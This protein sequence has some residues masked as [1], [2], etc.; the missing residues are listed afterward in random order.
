MDTSQL[1]Q[2]QYRAWCNRIQG[3]Y[4][5]DRNKKK[6]LK[7]EY[8]MNM[9]SLECYNTTLRTDI[10][11]PP[12]VCSS[13]QERKTPMN[14]QLTTNTPE[15]NMREYLNSRIFGIR[16]RKD[17]ELNRQFGLDTDSP[18]ASAEEAFER[19]KAGRYVINPD[20]N[21]M[22]YSWYRCIIWCD[23]SIKKDPE[24][25][26]LARLALEP[27]FKAIEDTIA[28]QSPQDAL[29]ALQAFEKEM[30]PTTAA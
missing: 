24:G 17:D 4:G 11:C 3:Y 16:N 27:K 18:P 1:D 10:S 28:I 12:T 22:Y 30:F 2:L 14:M 5:A 25:C 19:V 20:V 6:K 26:R 8:K 13:K 29:T 21:P 7:R 23:P 9:N 15:Q